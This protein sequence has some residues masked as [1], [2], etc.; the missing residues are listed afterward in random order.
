[1]TE[2][3][4]VLHNVR[5]ARR[6]P[7]ALVEAPRR[8][9]R[10]AVEAEIG[11]HGRVLVRPSGTGAGR[12][13]DGRGSH[14]GP[15]RGRRPAWRAP[16]RPPRGLVGP[17][18]SRRPPLHC[19]SA[20]RTEAA[21]TCG[22]HRSRSSARHPGRPR[23]GRRSSI[24]SA[25]DRRPGRRR[26]RPGG[27]PPRPDR[28]GRPPEGGRPPPAGTPGVTC[29]LR[30]RS[31]A[32]EAGALVG[33][34]VARLAGIERELDAGA[35]ALDTEH[36]EAVNAALIR[37]RDAAWAVQ[38]DRLPTAEKVRLLA[39]R[40]R[41]GRPSRPSPPCSRP[42]PPS[43]ALEV[44]GR[45]PPACT[46]RH[47]PRPRPHRP[48]SP[49]ARRGRDGDHLFETSPCAPP[50]VG[51]GTSVLSFVY[52]AAAEIGELGDNTR[53][54]CGPPSPPTSCSTSP[55]R[56][57]PRMPWSSATPAGPASGSSPRPTPIRSTPRDEVEAIPE[58]PL[59]HRRAQRRRRQLRRPQG[60]P[61][62]H[63]RPERSPPTRR[64]SPPWSPRAGWRRARGSTPPSGPR[65]PPWRARS[66][67]A[68]AAH[69]PRPP[70][71][72]AAG[73]RPGPLRRRGR[74]DLYIVASGP[75]V[76]S[77]RPRPTCAWTAR[78]RPTPTTPRPA[79]ARSWSSTAA[80]RHPSRGSTATP[81]TARP[82]R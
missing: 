10:A 9:H 79:G 34:A 75:T 3:P 58:G 13:G 73:Q 38:R 48:R 28:R 65:S 1:M 22:H 77:R 24:P 47:R 50:T 70:P 56:P 52:K 14:R 68:P 59:R 29:L 8:R 17:G 12:A 55:S 80:G 6:D 49:A 35:A 2:L 44:R 66:P 5:L 54:P 51:D 74:K 71:P 33:T 23:A 78:R 72:R 57:T 37:V 81:T 30:H 63:P 42:C 53:C 11:D 20:G 18:R 32:T 60:R 39:G 26:D 31:P 19:S 62:P 40:R 64:S 43:I 41:A 67:S 7:D 36:L 76:W 82:C 45:D 69:R 4:Q 21:V 46:C 61:R 27:P 16:W 25:A 15:G